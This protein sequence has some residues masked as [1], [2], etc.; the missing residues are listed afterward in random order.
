M[1]KKYELSFYKDVYKTRCAGKET[2]EAKDFNDAGRKAKPF[3]AKY[4]VVRY[5]IRALAVLMLTLT[6]DAQTMRVP[7]TSTTF[8]RLLL[9]S[10]SAMAARDLLGVGGTNGVG[11]NGNQFEVTTNQ[12]SIKDTASITNPV[13]YGKIV[14]AKAIGSDWGFVVGD[15]GTISK[16]QYQIVV[17]SGGSGETNSPYVI[18][19]GINAGVWTNCPE[20]ITIG[21]NALAY[22]GYATV[23]GP[24]AE[25][26][27]DRA[28]AFGYHAK[29]YKNDQIAL[30]NSTNTVTA[31]NDLEVGRNLYVTNSATITGKITNSLLSASY[32]VITDGNKALASSATSASELALLQGVT[33]NVQEQ[34]NGKFSLTGGSVSNTIFTGTIKTVGLATLSNAVV[35]SSL[36]VT[37]AVQNLG[38]MNTVGAVGIGGATTVSNN[39]TVN[40]NLTVGGAIT[41]GGVATLTNLVI[42]KPS[43]KVV[44]TNTTVTVDAKFMRLKSASNLALNQTDAFTS[45]IDGQMLIIALTSDS[46]NVGITNG[47][48]TYMSSHFTMTANDTITFI[49]SAG[50]SKWLELSRSV[51][52]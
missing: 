45:G 25:A 12:V 2:V 23:V 39:L 44:T 11:Y 16:D 14:S 50:I 35:E 10:D 48:G 7:V 41:V 5:V 13:F 26:W 32:A 18:I 24:N 40:S 8:T 17:G 27:N 43:D 51:N 21:R 46:A 33:A 3:L 47:A 34:I 22:K 29:T 6:V 52:P 36:I 49:Y 4:G 1:A 38:T 42:Y 20:S 9:Q 37:G 31:F 28:S 15:D 19:L 30:G